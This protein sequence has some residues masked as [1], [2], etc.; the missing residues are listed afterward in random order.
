MYLQWSYKC[1]KW[2]MSIEI[3]NWWINL[4]R[5]KAKC[6]ISFSLIGI[7]QI[8]LVQR[9]L[10]TKK[11]LLNRGRDGGLYRVV[12]AEGQILHPRISAR[13]ISNQC[14]NQQCGSYYTRGTITSLSCT[15]CRSI[16]ASGLSITN[17]VSGCC[18]KML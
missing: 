1:P 13:Q 7:Y 12:T 10:N 5:S 2:L 17:F 6:L 18:N 16:G 11:L 4:W 8:L 9:E 14:L 15:G 3:Q